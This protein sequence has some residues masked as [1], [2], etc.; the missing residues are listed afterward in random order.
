VPQIT[1]AIHLAPLVFIALAVLAGIGILGL[2]LIG[3]VLIFERFDEHRVF[4]DEFDFSAN[5][6]DGA[7][8]PDFVNE[9]VLRNLATHHKLDLVPTRVQETRGRNVQGGA[10]KGVLS[11]QLSNETTV[12]HEPHDDLGELVRRVVRHLHETGELNQSADL[13]WIEDIMLEA[14]PDFGEPSRASDAFGTWFDEHYPRGFDGVAPEQL[15]RELGSLGEQLPQTKICDRLRTSFSEIDD[16][17]PEAVLFFEGEWAVKN[18]GSGTITLSK[19][20]L[21]VESPGPEGRR[22]RSIPIPDNASIVMDVS[23]SDLTVHGRTRMVGVSRP[24][25]A[26][27]LATLRQY[28][29]DTGCFEVV[30][31]AVYQRVGNK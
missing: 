9:V 28:D 5:P 23:E 2:L 31:I 30:P 29:P 14:V 3:G 10:P 1:L 7:A 13:I 27:V 20:N 6:H 8:V 11:G 4:K 25:R 15:A 24:I 26:K 22:T 16:H 17:A 12:T 21:R 18:D 19:T